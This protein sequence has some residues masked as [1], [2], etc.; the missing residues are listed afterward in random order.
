MRIELISA[1][2][3]VKRNNG[4]LFSIASIRAKMVQNS[5]NVKKELPKVLHRRDLSYFL[6]LP[7]NHQ[8]EVRAE[9]KR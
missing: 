1:G 6:R 4:R 7:T 2:S 8:N 9:E 5:S 3:E